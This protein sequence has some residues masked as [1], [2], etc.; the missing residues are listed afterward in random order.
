MVP[1]P[2]FAQD[3]K[4][5]TLSG[6]FTKWSPAAVPEINESLLLAEI[7]TFLPSILTL[8]FGAEMVM[9]VK[10]F[11]LTLPRGEA[12]FTERLSEDILI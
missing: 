7:D 1:N 4:D 8:P 10:A 3:P 11:K 5:F 9:P 12:I 6:G 2:H